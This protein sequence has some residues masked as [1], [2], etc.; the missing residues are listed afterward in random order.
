MEEL[1]DGRRLWCRRVEIDGRDDE[2]AIGGGGRTCGGALA[3][4]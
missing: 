4:V 2:R 3:L 1:S